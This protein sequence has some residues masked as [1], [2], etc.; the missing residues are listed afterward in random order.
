MLQV[1]MPTPAPRDLPPFAVAD[2][3]GTDVAALLPVVRAVIAS[4]LRERRDHPDVEDC[5]SEALRRALEG[6]SRLRPNEALRPWLLG[7]ARHVAIDHLRAR[8]RAKLRTGNASND[9]EQGEQGVDLLVDPAPHPDDQVDQ[10]RRERRLLVAMD[11]LTEGQRKAMMM[12]HLEGL[13]YQEVADRLGVPLGTV[14]TWISRGRRT[15]AEQ[16]HPEMRKS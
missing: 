16:L 11:G 8:G 13:G 4:V 9:N 6:Q 2:E 3:F 10:K 1:H 15:L 12:F 5:A 7:I 14:A